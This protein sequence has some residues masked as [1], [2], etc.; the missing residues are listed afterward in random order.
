[1][2]DGWGRRHSMRLVIDRTI[3]FELNYVYAQR[4]I[5]IEQ[6]GVGIN[7]SGRGLGI[8]T[9]YPLKGDETLRVHFRRDP[10]EK[11]PPVSA[12]VVWTQVVDNCFRAGLEF[13]T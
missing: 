10:F 6:T 7:I 11:T 8:L 1:M 5:K 4:L 3:K 12:K 9:L 2:K 13:I